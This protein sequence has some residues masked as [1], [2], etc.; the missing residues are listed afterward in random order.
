MSTLH[1]TEIDGV[2]CAWVDTGRPTLRASLRFRFGM[3]DEPLPE[4]GWQHLLEHLVLTGREQ[5]TL[6]VNGAVS[7]L[8]TSLDLHGPVDSVAA[9]L[10]DITLWLS[11]P[12]LSGLEHERKVLAAEAQ[13]RGGGPVQRALSWRYGAIGPG[14]ASYDQPGL[15]RAAPENL[16]D[17]ARRVFTKANAV[18][19]LDGPPPPSL[20]LALPTG[21]FIAPGAVSPIESEPGS[22]G[23]GMLVLTGEVRRSVA[24]TLAADVLR[25]RVEDVL[26]HDIGHSYGVGSVYEP[27]D[28][29]RAVLGVMADLSDE[30]PENASKHLLDALDQLRDKGPAEDV[31]QQVVDRRL[32]ALRDPYAAVGIA[33][34]AASLHFSGLPAQDLPAYVAEVEALSSEDVRAV[35]AEFA[36]T[37]LLGSPAPVGPR[38]PLITDALE[39]PGTP[40]DGVV[41]RG[42][43]WPAD[44]SLMVLTANLMEI[45]GEDFARR[46]PLSSLA[47]Y[48]K[49]PDGRRS[50]IRQDGFALHFDPAAWRHGHRAVATLD[51]LVAADLHVE[52]DV[53]P[54][55]APQRLNGALRWLGGFQRW[56][57]NASAALSGPVFILSVVALILTGAAVTVAV[58]LALGLED[59]PVRSFASLPLI[60]VAVL[61]VTGRP[62]AR[63]SRKERK[64][65]RRPD[66]P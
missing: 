32:Q 9:T 43:N 58:L 26:R 20:T 40:A 52:V 64:P 59:T 45:H 62:L 15:S 55:T 31:Y 10:A 6:Q 14:A 8:E 51:N 35:V 56:L 54:P 63:N 66:Q 28:D 50:L 3:A 7:L 27:V 22:Y 1:T 29:D 38:L 48:F 30:S 5:G 49:A 17:R 57:A 53:P 42:V 19:V 60:V 33:H 11:E 44:D 46:A 16:H 61:F 39:G 24:A 36:T 47:A 65:G 34:Y 13:A 18:L 12:D 2:W 41:F 21:D 37:L 25:V 23:D 4:S